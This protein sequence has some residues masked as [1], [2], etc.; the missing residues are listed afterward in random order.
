MNNHNQEILF[1][2][3]EIKSCLKKDSFSAVYLARHIFLEKD[4]FLKVL[5]TQNLPDE[6]LLVRFKREAKI[7][8]RLDHP[9]IIKV[10]DFGTY[11]EFFYIS[12]EY[13]ESHDLR[14]W[15]SHKSLNLAQKTDVVR[16][17]I[18]ALCFAHQQGIIHRDLKPENILINDQLQLKVADFGLALVKDESRIT[19][20]QSVVGTP[21]YMSP[22]QI[23]GE[24]LTIQTDQFNLGLI[25]FELFTGKNPF[26]GRDAG[27][28]INNILSYDWQT[29]HS[30]MDQIPNQVRP[31][32]ERLLKKSPDE[33]FSQSDEMLRFFEKSQ[34]TPSRPFPV[35]KKNRKIV[36]L[37]GPFVLLMLIITVYWLVKPSQPV[38]SPNGIQPPQAAKKALMNEQQ[39]EVINQN[40][41]VFT[42]TNE[43]KQQPIIE[44]QKTELTV[45]AKTNSSKIR[46][47]S[48]PVKTTQ[49]GQILF[50]CF[51]WAEVTI[52]SQIHFTT[53]LEH[54]LSLSAGAH[55]F[56]LKHPA[57]PLYRGRFVLKAGEQ[58][59]F[60][61]K[62]DTLFAYLN[63]Q[64]HP[65][66]KIYIDGHYM[67]Q[68]P[69]QQPIVLLP[70]R[71]FLTVL[72]EQ[73]QA[74]SDSI[75]LKAGDTLDLKINLWQFSKH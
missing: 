46:G 48:E 23:R 30:Q 75:L 55:D 61:I 26:L 64:V 63:C 27:E 67:E 35:V 21:A 32:L 20:M 25:I 2:K 10:L 66:G 39:V 6:S 5:N 56:V 33:R 9:H 37:L 40:S 42:S 24:K 17:L 14:Y 12:F 13:F 58:R 69:L 53:P 29:L 70:G 22:E 45:S 16:Q 73:F 28:T 4:I 62:L 44:E 18:K 19:E 3:F 47:V 52:D 65:W 1:E 31:L 60:N 43:K 7:L 36:R 34:E 54:P 50:D 15:I 49:T 8:A 11:Q 71:H 57:F 74:Y 59:Q 68:T 72:N 38:L 41:E 51:P